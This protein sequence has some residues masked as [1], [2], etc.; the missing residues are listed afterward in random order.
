MPSR[1]NAAMHGAAVV[2]ELHFEESGAY[3]RGSARAF[4]RAR[5]ERGRPQRDPSQ[6]AETE[7]ADRNGNSDLTAK[8]KKGGKEQRGAATDIAQEARRLLRIGLGKS[9]DGPEPQNKN[10]NAEDNLGHGYFS[11]SINWTAPVDCRFCRSARAFIPPAAQ[12]AAARSS[13]ASSC[14][15]PGAKR[16]KAPCVSRATSRNARSQT[17]S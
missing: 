2:I 17:G 16:Q 1:E 3:A 11:C 10:G 13:S 6:Q 5:S 7:D 12:A 8:Q 14:A 15:A 4:L 9:V